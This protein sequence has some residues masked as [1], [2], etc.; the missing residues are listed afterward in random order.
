MPNQNGLGVP[1]TA[2]QRRELRG[3]IA[4]VSQA[5]EA[6]GMDRVFLTNILSG[7]RR[8]SAATLRRIARHVGLDAT[9]D[10]R[11]TATLTPRRR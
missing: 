4:N 7:K 10:V 11:I 5:A 9:V 8:P 6:I 1:L 2:A 3:G